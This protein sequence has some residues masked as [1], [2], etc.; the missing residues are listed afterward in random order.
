[1][2]TGARINYDLIAPLYDGLAQAF[3]FGAI[4]ASKLAQ[5]AFIRPGD[6]VLYLGVD[7]GEEAARAAARGAIV[8]CVDLSQRMLD[9][10]QRRLERRNAP[11]ELIVG[12]ALDHQRINHYDVVAGNFFF[13]LFPA[14]VMPRFLD[15][16]A[17]LVKPGG[18]LLIADFSMPTGSL[19]ARLFHAIYAKAAMAVFWLGGLVA[20]HP[21][22]DYSA[23]FSR[24]G[25]VEMHR[26]NFRLFRGG[27][28]VFCML[29]ARK[30]Q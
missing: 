2:A 11:A 15:H 18:L 8:T 4:R 19:P 20:W 27:P 22:Y 16:A 1:M 23:H 12:D 30:A 28:I 29:G 26:Q 6:R 14:T 25:L 5:L 13:N 10:V 3:S 7:G 17:T 21:T 9:R 24:L